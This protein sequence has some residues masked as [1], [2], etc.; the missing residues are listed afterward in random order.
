MVRF[1]IKNVQAI[2]EAKREFTFQYGQ[3]Y[4]FKVY[5][6]KR[7]IKLIYIP[8]WLDLLLEVVIQ[9]FY[10]LNDLHSNMV[11]FIIRIIAQ[12]CIIVFIIYIPIWLDLLSITL[13]DLKWMEKEFTFQYGQIYYSRMHHLYF[14]PFPHLHSNM[15]RFIMQTI[16]LKE[17]NF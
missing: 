17:A 16:R 2:V 4:Y 6:I 10:N 11:R 15:V 14:E 3:I 12:Y 7:S 9:S 8:I 1:I 13:R 5:F